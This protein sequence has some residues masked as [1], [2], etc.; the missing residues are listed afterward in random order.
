LPDTPPNL[1]QKHLGRIIDTIKSKKHTHIATGQY[2]DLLKHLAVKVDEHI[3]S[4]NIVL[5]YAYRTLGHL[6]IDPTLGGEANP[7]FEEAKTLFM[8]GQDVDRI[9][10]LLAQSL[11]VSPRHTDSWNYLGAVLTAQKKFED[12][13]VLHTQ[14]YQIDKG[15]LETAA[16]IADC[17]YRLHYPNLASSYAHQILRFNSDRDNAFANKIAKKIL[18]KN[19]S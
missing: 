6:D 4:Q 16:N 5:Y 15:D 9:M 2:A 14:A 13:L 12:A 18:E 8:K 1:Y 11:E 10:H 19:L 3:F 17:Y 7:Y